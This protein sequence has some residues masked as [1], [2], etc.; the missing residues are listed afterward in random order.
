MQQSFKNK[1][2]RLVRGENGASVALTAIVLAVAILFNVVLYLLDVSYGLYLFRPQEKTYEVSDSAAAFFEQAMRDG[3]RVQIIFCRPEDSLT[4]HATGAFVLRTAKQM[5]EKYPDFL[6]IDY[7]NIITQRKA[8]GS[9]VDFSPYTQNGA[10]KITRDSVI[11]ASGD[12]NRVVTDLY[13]SAGY[14]DF[15]A[16]DASG[17]AVAFKGE[18]IMTGMI[19]WV[20][21]EHHPKAYLT[22]G[23]GETVEAGLY[24]MLSCAGY[25]VDLLDLRKK[26]V[27]ADAGLVIISAPGTD[28]ESSKEDSA[29]RSEIA[30]LADYLARGGSLYVALDPYMKRLAMLEEF[31]SGY[32]ISVSRIEGEGGVKNCNI[33]RD[34][35]N[36]ITTDGY[37]FV[38]GVNGETP[39]GVAVAETLGQYD[40]GSVVI[41]HAAALELSKGATALLLSS[42]AAETFSSGERTGADGDYPVAAI[43]EIAGT[44][45]HLGKTGRVFMTASAFLAT[46][47]SLN[48]AGY[49]N[50]DFLYA[51]FDEF[52][53]S[54]R[55]PYGTAILSVETAK[56][57]NLTMQTAKTYTFLILLVPA[58]LAGVGVFVS[59]RRKNR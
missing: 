5:V 46:S 39:L 55:P 45:E 24:T 57:E 54:Q 52:F 6:S 31:L 37:T 35:R 32:G 22:T 56:L 8:D 28:F 29:I 1:W 41:S 2:S 15:Y 17:N 44:G 36:A 38:A 14:A 40:T 9:L 58:L 16:L 7:W 25:E 20:L 12:R 13:S 21:T 48:T 19:T 47:D 33:L 11:F 4:D 34:T 49:A 10:V 23:H 59:L 53:D 18:E 30:R 50:K 27:P 26:E 51:L 43:S 3:Q 42:R